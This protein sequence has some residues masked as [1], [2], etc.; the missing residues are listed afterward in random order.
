MPTTRAPFVVDYP[1][2]RWSAQAAAELV[3]RPAPAM[4]CIG[5]GWIVSDVEVLDGG[6]CLLVTVG[7]GT[8][9]GPMPAVLIVEAVPPAIGWVIAWLVVYVAILA[10]VVWLVAR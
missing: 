7:T 5:P 2:Q 10:G 9:T 8:G 3:G 6:D 1:C 4:W